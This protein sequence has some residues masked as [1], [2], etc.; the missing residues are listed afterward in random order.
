MG[1]SSA[2]HHIVTEAAAD[3]EVL[4][5]S[6]A[7]TSDSSNGVQHSE[8]LEEPRGISVSMILFSLDEDNSGCYH[9]MQPP[10]SPPFSS[11][12]TTRGSTSRGAS[13]ESAMAEVTHEL[14]KMLAKLI[15][16]LT[17]ERLEPQPAQ[18][19][20]AAVAAASIFL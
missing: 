19:S 12:F 13:P 15:P 16:A 17:I 14:K 5:E 3:A 4:A 9:S 20:A 7:V 18:A 2:S 10:S 11:L 1:S 8:S 6:S